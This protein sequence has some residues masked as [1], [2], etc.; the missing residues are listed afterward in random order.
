MSPTTRKNYIHGRTQAAVTY[1]TEYS[2][3][4]QWE[5]ENKVSPDSLRQRLQIV[6]GRT[7]AVREAIDQ[8][9]EGDNSVRRKINMRYLEAPRRFPTPDTMH[10]YKPVHWMSWV[11]E[12]AQKIIKG[13][14]EEI[15]LLNK[16]T[17]HSQEKQVTHRQGPKS[18]NRLARSR[19]MKN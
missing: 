2:N 11:Q 13:L 3:T 15:S 18:T 1:V 12:E 19:Q 5:L 16:K 4:K 8:A 7:N 17:T 6:F 14:D 9:I 10:N